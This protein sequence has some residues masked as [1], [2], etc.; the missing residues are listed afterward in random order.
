MHA[1]GVQAAFLTDPSLDPFSWVRCQVMSE[2][3]QPCEG[4]GGGGGGRSRAGAFPLLLYV[5]AIVATGALYLA[6]SHSVSHA[7]AGGAEDLRFFKHKVA[8]KLPSTRSQ[9]ENRYAEVML[10]APSW[11]AMS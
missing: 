8:Q 2:G 6:S 9:V 11:G 1:R 4:P 3:A 5:L 10:I 7:A